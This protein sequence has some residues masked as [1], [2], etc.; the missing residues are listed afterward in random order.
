DIDPGLLFYL[1]KV[2]YMPEE[3]N[4]ILNSESGMKGLS[5]VSA[6]MADKGCGRLRWRR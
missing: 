6:Y 3:L 5:G 2:G 1:M 4:R